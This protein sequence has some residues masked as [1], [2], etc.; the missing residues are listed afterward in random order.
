MLH[1]YKITLEYDGTGYRGWQSQKNARSVQGTLIEAAETIFGNSIELQGAGRTDAGVHA[2]AQVAHLAAARKI[3]PG[4]LHDAFNDLLPASIN[5]LAVEAA[6]P[7]FHAR[8]HATL[9]SYLYIVS[10]RR[11]AFGKRYVWWVKDKLDLKRMQTIMELFRGFHDFASFADKRRDK[12]VSTTVH[13]STTELHELGDLLVFRIAGSHFLWKMVRRLV[14]ITVEAGKGNLAVAEVKQMLTTFS[15]LPAQLT[16]P[17]SGLFLER[18]LYAGE[19]E[20]P[21]GLP[22]LPLLFSTRIP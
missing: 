8:H 12:E 16:A 7:D 21:Q 15:E 13:L 10:R 11:T 9:R 4:R 2:L 1:K 5:V 22:P 3:N 18:V 17:A 6:A 19:K 14:G 20:R